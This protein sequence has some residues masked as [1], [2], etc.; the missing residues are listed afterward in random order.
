MLQ[1]NNRH[2]SAAMSQLKANTK[3]NAVSASFH[4]VIVQFSKIAYS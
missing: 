2:L 1:E 3:Q 4:P